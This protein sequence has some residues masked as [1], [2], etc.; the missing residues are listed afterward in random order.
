M[1]VYFKSH[2]L[3]ML[4]LSILL[5]IEIELEA[6]DHLD[7]IVMKSAN[8]KKQPVSKAALLLIYL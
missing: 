8:R 7:I 4:S 2:I 6:K 3:E 5:E 1:M